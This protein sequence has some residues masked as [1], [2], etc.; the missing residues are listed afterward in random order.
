LLDLAGADL[1]QHCTVGPMCTVEDNETLPDYTVIYG[2]NSRRLDQ[3]GVDDLKLKMVRRHIDVLKKLI[4]N[5]AA[6]F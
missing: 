2:V 4:P 1:P 5:S 6:K 3:S